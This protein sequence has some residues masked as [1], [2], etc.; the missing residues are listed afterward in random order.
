MNNGN[1]AE[2]VT[3]VKR[4]NYNELLS[5]MFKE[6]IQKSFLATSTLYFEVN[7]T[8]RFASYHNQSDC[9]NLDAVNQIE[10]DEFVGRSRKSR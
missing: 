5:S 3:K 10:N 4:K 7:G 1:Q 9:G 8:K 6:G 2:V